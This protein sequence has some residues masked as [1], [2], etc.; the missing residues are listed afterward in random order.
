MTKRF[1]KDLQYYKFCLYGFLK[2]LRLFEPFL[3]LFLESKEITYTQIGLLYSIKMI[4]RVIFEIPSGIIADALG[5]RGTML[6]SYSWADS[7]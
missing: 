1:V 3:I 6:F 4:I 2:N 7:W 5:R